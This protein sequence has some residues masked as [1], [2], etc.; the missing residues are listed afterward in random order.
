MCLISNIT[1]II[2]IPIFE[3]W[4]CVDLRTERSTKLTRVQNM[5][6]RVGVHVHLLL[7]RPPNYTRNKDNNK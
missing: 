6:L 4:S 7:D 1:I 3:E 2:S 5:L